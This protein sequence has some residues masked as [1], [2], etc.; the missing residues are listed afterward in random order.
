MKSGSIGFAFFVFLIGLAAQAVEELPQTFTLD[1]R[2]YGDSSGNSPLL[3][4]GTLKI[5][6]LSEDETCVLYEESQ[7]F[8]TRSSKGYFSVRVGS[9]SSGAASAKRTAAGD[10]GHSM[11]KIFS[12]VSAGVAGKLVSNQAACVYHPQL[13]DAR[14]V[15]VQ[16]TPSDGVTRTLS[17]NMA[18]DTV[19][20]AM[21]AER[22]ESLQ[23]FSSA[24]FIKVSP[25]VT[26][27]NLENLFSV[28]SLP[29]LT[30]LLS[31]DPS[32]YLTSGSNGTA[33]LPQI[34]GNPSSG[35]AEGQFWYDSSA[36]TLKYHDGTAVR[37]V[38]E[39]ILPNSVVLDGGN[40]VSAPMSIGTN[41]NQGLDLK[42]NN[43]ARISILNSG[44]IG[45][46]T[47]APTG[48][49]HIIGTSVAGL[50]MTR[51][52]SP[53][54]TGI[55]FQ[56]SWGTSA[57]P[58]A[59][60]AGQYIGTME[61]M[62][63][64]GASYGSS[65]KIYGLA[66][67]ATTSSDSSG[68]LAFATTATGATSVSER[69]RI[70]AD[71]N[72]GIGT[73][74]PTTSRV[75]ISATDTTSYVPT[76]LAKNR[77]DVLSVQNPDTTADGYTGIFLEHRNA[78]VAMGRIALHGTF[79]GSPNA[80]MTFGLRGSSGGPGTIE[81]MRITDAGN[82]GIG[83]TTPSSAL[84]VTGNLT[85]TR[86]ANRTIA[87][88]DSVTTNA[89]GGHLTL[90]AGKGAG[91]G[92][93]GN[94]I[95]SSGGSSSAAIGSGNVTISTPVANSG[96]GGDTGS[97]T[98]QTGS[99]PSNLRSIGNINLIAGNNQASATGGVSPG[100]GISLNS[101]SGSGG[102]GGAIGGSGGAI[103]F[104]TG[105]GGPANT[106]GSIGGSGGSVNITTGAGGA[107]PAGG[108]NGNGGFM[109]FQA[110]A[111]GAGA[112]TAGKFGD[113][114]MQ[115]SGGNVGIGTLTPSVAL[116]V[117]SKTDAI[118][119]PASTTANR[120]A[121]AANGM[122]RYNT[123]NNKLESYINGGWQ[124]LAGAA[125]GGGYLSS[126]GGSL[127]GA[128]TISSGGASIAGG[129]NNSSGGITNAGNI[130]G[131]GT[132][133]TGAGALT[134]A[135]GGT[136]QSL[137]LSSS[138][139]GAVNIGTGSGIGFSI[140]DLGATTANYVTVKGAAAGAAPAIGTAGSDTNV[141]LVLAPK[142]QGNVGIGTAAPASKLTIANTASATK[143]LDITSSSNVIGSTN[144]AMAINFSAGQVNQTNT[145]IS[146]VATGAGQGSSKGI[147]ISQN[148]RDDSY[149]VYVNTTKNWGGTALFGTAT[150]IHSA[151]ST[152]SSL[153]NSYGGYFDNT[154]VVGNRA[155]GIYA[156]GV[157]GATDAA[158]L[159]AAVGGVEKF[160]VASSGS[161]GVGTTSPRSAVEIVDAT[162][163]A[164]LRL[165]S[166][167]WGNP[168]VHTV[169]LGADSNG[170]ALVSGGI[171]FGTGGAS[172][173]MIFN[174]NSDAT[175][176]SLNGYKHVYQTWMSGNA[177]QI[178]FNFQNNSDWAP[179]LAGYTGDI[180]KVSGNLASTAAETYRGIY[181]TPGDNSSSIANTIYGLYTD[182]SGGT[183]ASATRYAAVFTGGNVGIGTTTPASKLDVN[184]P[185]RVNGDITTPTTFKLASPGTASEILVVGSNA[186]AGN[187]TRV[188][189]GG[190]RFV[191]SPGT[192]IVNIG[193]LNGTST[194]NLNGNV[195]GSTMSLDTTYVPEGFVINSQQVDATRAYVNL[196]QSGTTAGMLGFGSWDS[197]LRVNNALNNPV[198]FGTNNT[199]RMRITAAGNVGVGITNPGN[200][201]LQVFSN[202]ST[203]DKVLQVSGSGI[204]G[205]QSGPFYGVY[206]DATAN[207]NAT[208]RY[209][210]YAYGNGGGGGPNY[211][212]YGTTQMGSS[213]RLAVGVQGDVVVNSAAVN[214]DPTMTTPVAGVMATASTSGTSMSSVST[215]LL[216]RN[217]SVYGAVS[218]GAYIDALAGPT[219]VVPLRID[220][221]T[222][223]IMR[224]TSTGRLG[225][226][227]ASPAAKLDVMGDA[228]IYAGEASNS[229]FS[230]GK[231]GTGISYNSIS[232][233]SV[234]NGTYPSL[235][236]S[237]STNGS[238]I[239]YA[240]GGKLR[241]IDNTSGAATERMRIDAVGN[242]G[243][244]TASPQAKLD[245]SGFM[246]MAKNAAA[247]A[248][249]T[250]ALDGSVALTSLYTICICKGG[251]TKWVNSTDG[252]TDCAW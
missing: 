149:G 97:I 119:V 75:E 173:N 161:V 124:D 2:L 129:L 29:R 238:E 207:N 98:L 23:G 37:S 26:Q 77:S 252:A 202:G 51:S 192:T 172:P 221:N 153:A 164:Q 200:S 76:L 205:G 181:L 92:A 87:V 74:N 188:D 15:R 117:G 141:N 73:T 100:G 36:H 211:G 11:T 83:T 22:A 203:N 8:D 218:Y 81:R 72:V 249:C 251:A 187:T 234:Y 127:S 177:S 62:S 28:T 9:P 228:R 44:N 110:G 240:A 131:V 174:S 243:I 169:T 136:N 53:W 139:T 160:R 38:S 45:I 244:G 178:G 113:I 52:G 115:T 195:V 194:I 184:G 126:A 17:P 108:V 55:R 132:N 197:V 144:S 7:T 42:T 133:I 48:N 102:S 112:G 242:V 246:R 90:Q 21:V 215:A 109:R 12:N 101:G 56:S 191:N 145:G 111:P 104:A 198:A 162:W 13:G 176:L 88:G 159:V 59:S 35:L 39:F 155:Y 213:T 18:L 189:I 43:T 95:L 157:A 208:A 212:V 46:G 146:L 4:T 84:E 32:R 170:R 121:T 171:K 41:S 78:N 231:S 236:L 80:A 134:V 1:G 204:A 25:N 31:I 125:T 168:A 60:T 201:K 54:G 89:A 193:G 156:N 227:T 106:A 120:P 27:S 239:T 190:N 69:M 165:T 220:Y 216:A 93:G 226:G 137:S 150:G 49:L 223:E 114:V 199:E 6:I 14:Y 19:P 148:A 65:A 128:L 99:S 175:Y 130:T 179:S 66:A 222:S 219:T 180:M 152:D 40:A 247:P 5:Q 163:G 196:Q 64:N 105:A 94:L 230:V 71:G 57:A 186:A 96:S 47:S 237:Q 58:L 138:G 210:V 68:H 245:I 185:M 33:G 10:S 142:G 224:V 50:D 248:A 103:N 91:I 61:F 16:M 135:A 3:D 79:F 140:L 166:N 34:G 20:N 232:I 147:D 151:V 30:G 122:I 118:R 233:W 143:A 183:N 82:V 225:I 167:Y 214:N 217:Q 123:D 250:A 154:S 209:G 206:V 86:E 24:D 70:A 182:V 158:P 229:V 107:A 241:F 116:D 85:L 67:S 63:H 235:S